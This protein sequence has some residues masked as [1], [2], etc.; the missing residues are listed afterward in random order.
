MLWFESLLFYGCEEREQEREDVDI[1][2]LPTIVEKAILPKLTGELWPRAPHGAR[3]GPAP[4]AARSGRSRL[5]WSGGA[6]S[7]GGN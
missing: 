2:L 1:A 3:A 5:C 6:G 4:R 7:W